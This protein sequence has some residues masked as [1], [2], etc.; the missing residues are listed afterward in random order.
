MKTVVTMDRE[1]Q[2]TLPAAAREALG[3]AEE[4]QF[5]VEVRRALKE[6]REGR[7]FQLT[8]ADLDARAERPR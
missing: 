2:L 4:T 3:L 5:E 1:G 7:V 6:A 8:E